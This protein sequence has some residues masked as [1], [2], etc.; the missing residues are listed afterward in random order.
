MASEQEIN[1][2][3]RIETVDRA[4]TNWVSKMQ[5]AIKQNTDDSNARHCYTKALGQAD[6]LKEAVDTLSSMRTTLFPLD[7]NKR[8]LLIER[9]Q[10]IADLQ[11]SWKREV[12]DF[13]SRQWDD[14][15]A[16]HCYTQSVDW[17]SS[18]EQ[19]IDNLNAS[20]TMLLV[21]R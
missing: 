13:A 3:N 2:L 6:N 10:N 1:L 8:S 4:C 9:I 5:W 17:E 16:R 19:E 11:K 18:L 12:E 14:H 21:E 7:D 20:C 15:N